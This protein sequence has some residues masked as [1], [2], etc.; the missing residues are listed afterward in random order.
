M[1][2]AQQFGDRDHHRDYYEHRYSPPVS[3]KSIPHGFKRKAST[4]EDEVEH[5]TF[6]SNS[7]K[8]L[9]LGKDGQCSLPNTTVLKN[10]TSNARQPTAVGLSPVT[11]VLLG[12]S[13]SNQCLSADAQAVVRR[14]RFPDDRN[15]FMPLDETADRVWVHDIDAEV[16]EIEAEEARHGG[17][18]LSEAAKEYSK[19]PE[20]LLKQNPQAE[21]PAANMQV[22]LYQDPISIS[23]PEEEDAVRRTI[24]EARKRMRDKQAE[25]REKEQ[26]SVSTANVFYA[27]NE[28][29][30]NNGDDDMDLD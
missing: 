23:L 22:I 11:N 28:P 26:L 1:T 2:T 17:I 21:D 15:D 9:R 5:Q 19:I 10:A 20:H 4:Q 25:E 29:Q 7:F 3:P 13:P 16:A 14:H 12:H 24:V 18:E 6:I 27:S 30:N 8:K